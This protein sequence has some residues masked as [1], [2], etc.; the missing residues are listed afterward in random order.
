MANVRESIIFGIEIYDATA[1]ATAGFKCSGYAVGVAYDREAL[2][3]KKVA[4]CVVG[5][6]LLE[7]EFGIGPNL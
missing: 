1:G 6:V 7:G 2:S 3:F 4:Y 5:F